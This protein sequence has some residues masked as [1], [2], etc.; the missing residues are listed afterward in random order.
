MG[1]IIDYF[2]TRLLIIFYLM[3]KNVSTEKV[4]LLI[5][6]NIKFRSVTDRKVLF[7]AKD[8]IEKVISS[9]NYQ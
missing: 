1:S 6:W 2:T 3:K 9:W 7:S 4:A 5:V 8:A